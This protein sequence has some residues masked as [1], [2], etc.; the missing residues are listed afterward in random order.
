MRHCG[1]SLLAS[2]ILASCA[3]P[4]P[5]GYILDG[6]VGSVSASDIQ[7]AI[8]AARER[9][10]SEHR[11]FMPVF[12]IE[13]IGSD[14][15]YVYCGPHYRAAVAA[16]AVTVR[17]PRLGGKWRATSLTEEPAINSNERVIVT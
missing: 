15:I 8:Q 7:L 11:A 10:V 1:V 17:V 16:G 4:E 2:L 12:H 13:V 14:E 6:R 5:H 9:F 3:E